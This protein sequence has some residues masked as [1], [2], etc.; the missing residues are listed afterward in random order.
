LTWP[1]RGNPN[2]KYN[3]DFTRVTTDPNLFCAPF[4]DVNGDG[5]YNVY[6]GDYPLIQGDNMVWMVFNDDVAH[7]LSSALPLN[8]ELQV[9]VYAFDCAESDAIDQ[10]LFA[11]FEFTNRS[12]N[13]YLDTYMGFFTDFDLGCL[14][15]DYV[16]TLP[17]E[18][19]NF[20]YN[21]S[22]LDTNC[23]NGEQGFGPNVPVQSISFL[24]KEMNHSL[25]NF[26]FNTPPG[27]G[28]PTT[29]QEYYNCISGKW[30]DGTPLT[31]GGLGYNPGST[32][33]VNHAF[34]GNPSAPQGWSMC[35]TVV[36]LTDMRTIT[37]HGPFEFEAG[38]TFQISVAFTFHPN[39]EHPCPDIFSAVKPTVAQ[40]QT[41]QSDGAL[42]AQLDLGQVVSLISG[43][44]ITLDAGL[45]GGTNYSWSTGAN[46]PSITVTQPGAY[47]VTATSATGCQWEDN[48]LVQLSTG[49]NTISTPA[50]WTIHPNPASGSALIT[51][52]NGV[53]TGDV[54]VLFRNSQGSVVRR[55][56]AVSGPQYRL[57]TASLSSGMYWVEIW[58]GSQFGGAKK[59]VVGR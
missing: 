14:S 52:N 29:A 15:D 59:L 46:T 11:S 36:P 49:T 5:V 37:S 53:E 13:D 4:V 24:N 20:A 31:S 55:L 9:S 10:S 50:A 39:I 33:F 58:Y 22:A 18:N 56:E 44:S 8:M 47:A 25:P 54:M 57:D 7:E 48:V 41:W 32:D 43:Q 17:E 2:F 27:T 19:T 45:P 30:R 26:T 35:T 16:G 40:M 3:L 34:P 12:T 42:D 23:P 21:A 51:F 38:D 28:G 1:G 6:D